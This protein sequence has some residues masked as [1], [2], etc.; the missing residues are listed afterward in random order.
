MHRYSKKL[1]FAACVGFVSFIL[2]HP[3]KA[4]NFST[5]YQFQGGADGANPV[6]GVLNSNGSFYGTTI[7]GGG[8]QVGTVFQLVPPATAGA[9]NDKVLHSF[10][11]D[12]TQAFGDLISY[13]TSVLG[14]TF[15][16]TL[17]GNG[18]RVFQ[19]KPMVSPVGSWKEIS[20]HAFG[21]AGDGWGPKAELI[22]LGSVYYGTTL[23]GG[24]AGCK[25][26]TGGADGCGTLFQLKAPAIAGG[27]WTE[28]VIYSF[29]GGSDGSIASSSLVASGGELY[30][31]TTVGGTGNCHL[32]NT[33]GGCGTVFA[34]T[35]QGVKTTIYSFAGGADGAYPIGKL[36]HV[37]GAFYGTT[38]AGGGTG[39]G[40]SG[41]GT[42]FRLRPPAVAGG[43][44]REVILH[45][46]AGGADGAAP[47]AG[48]LNIPPLSTGTGVGTLY[49]TT[50]LG[51]GAGCGGDG[52]GTLFKLPVAGVEKGLLGIESVIHAFQGQSDGAFPIGDLINYGGPLGTTEFGGTVACP[53]GKIVAGYQGCGTVFRVSN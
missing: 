41:C 8:Q 20:L 15:S 22:K 47:V 13:K 30:G 44:W 31:I 46:F 36:I 18:G 26:Y 1:R 11:A 53:G 25:G 27:A 29:K 38:S 33:S 7:G 42:I 10:A 9:W 35:P 6:T 34:V 14:T 51:G 32:P 19:L 39:C 45:A 43:P 37:Q 52:C 50:T 12:G 28:K 17:S 48:L 4:E 21:S 16:N 24:I 23:A 40:G 3:A 2:A 49:G 5:V